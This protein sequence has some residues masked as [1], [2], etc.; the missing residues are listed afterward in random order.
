MRRLSRALGQ[1]RLLALLV[2]A[3]VIAVRSIDPTPV[4]LLRMRSF[5]LLQEIF[6]R[7]TQ[8]APVVIVDIDDES[9]ST[10]GQWPWP[11]TIVA[12]LADRLTAM[13]AAV[14]GFDME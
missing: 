8:E 7:A 6:P 10:I 14:I 11:R 9:L 12:E 1:G 5:D 3:A 13:D 2:L 4:Q